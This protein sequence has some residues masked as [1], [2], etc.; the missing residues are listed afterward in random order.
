MTYRKAATLLTEVIKNPTD[1]IKLAEAQNH[2][3]L[4]KVLAKLSQDDLV[5]L[6]NVAKGGGIIK[7]TGE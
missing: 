6:Q 3:Q 2:R 5:T 1:K 4:G 7:C